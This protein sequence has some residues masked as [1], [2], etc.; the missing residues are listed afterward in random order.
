MKDEAAGFPSACAAPS[1]P[2]MR[3]LVTGAAGFIGSTLSHRFLDRGDVVVGIDNL[4]DYY[5]PVLKRARLARLEP[6]RGFSFRQLDVADRPAMAT[7]FRDGGFQ[8]VVHLAAQA[9][10]RYSIEN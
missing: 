2:A 3:I 5:D 7:L 1:C 4:N 10:V 9:G 6:K 8:R